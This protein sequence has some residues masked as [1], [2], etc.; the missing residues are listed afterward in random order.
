MVERAELFKLLLKKEYYNEYGHVLDA[1]IFPDVLQDLYESLM[2]AHKTTTNGISPRELLNYHVNHNPTLTAANKQ[3]VR[4]ILEKVQ[5]AEP[6]SPEIVRDTVEV[7]LKQLK[8]NR[9]ANAAIQIAHGKSN[10]FD[11]IYAIL[12][13]TDTTIDVE[14]TTKDIQ[15][16]IDFVDVGYKWEFNL[17]DLQEAIGSVGPGV[18]TVFAAPVNNGKSLLG[19]NFIFGRGGYAEQGANCLYIGNEESTQVSMVRGVSCYFGKSFEEIKNTSK[20]E[21]TSMQEEFNILTENVEF[22]HDVTMTYSKL[23]KIIED[24]KPDIVFIDMLD[25]MNVSGNFSRKDEELGAIY[26]EARKLATTHN[27]AV[28][29]V[30]QTNND[31]VGTLKITQNQLASSRVEKAANADIILT[32]GKNNNAEDADVRCIYVAKAKRKGN[33]KEVMCKINPELSRLIP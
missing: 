16:L 21:L 32:L 17:P 28:F 9:L 12:N 3:V 10:D 29:G 6:I 30:S 4:E 31:S 24:K 2:A 13:D 20:E 14:Y 22:V 23:R 15:E 1:E 26:A 11:E 25:K 7:A 19:I 18:F 8:A 27:C 33:G 5:E